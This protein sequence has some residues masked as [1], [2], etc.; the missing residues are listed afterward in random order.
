VTAIDT[1][2][3]AVTLSEVD[4][5]TPAKLAEILVD[6]ANAVA[7]TRPVA[8]TTAV[9]G[10]DELQLTVEVRSAVLPSL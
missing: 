5:D 1:I 6:P 9:A 7:V 2:V 3:G 4:W 10:T 8:L